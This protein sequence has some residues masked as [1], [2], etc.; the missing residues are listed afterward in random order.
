M[1]DQTAAPESGAPAAPAP[2]AP[3]PSQPAAPPSWLESI[4]DPEARALVEQKKYGSPN[5]V[6]VAYRHMVKLHGRA[7]DVIGLPDKEDDEAGWATVYERLGRPGDANS[8][9][10]QPE[11]G[12]TPN[13]EYAAAIK[14]A[15]FKAG[16]SQKQFAALAKANDGFVKQAMEKMQAEAKAKDQATLQ[17]IQKAFGGE[18]EYTMAMEAG[19]RAVRAIGIDNETL[20][21]LDAAVGNVAVQKLFATL[22][23][24]LAKEADFIEGVDAAGNGPSPGAALAELERMKG[25]VEFQKSLLSPM[26]PNHKSNLAKWQEQ[27]RIAFSGGKRK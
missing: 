26:H 2:A 27:Q 8:Y 17:D 15:A 10:Y 14:D 22:G 12:V 9:Q 20:D 11:E 4:T 1:T 23:Q 24:K 6:A 3:P 21:R 25:D 5:D 7:P 16:I 18:R 19:K 13:E